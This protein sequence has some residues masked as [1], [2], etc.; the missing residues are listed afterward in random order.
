M[1]TAKTAGQAEKQTRLFFRL[2]CGFS[3]ARK[4]SWRRSSFRRR[5]FGFVFKPVRPLASL[6][7]SSPG[8]KRGIPFQSFSLPI[9]L[10]S[11]NHIA[12]R[13]NPN[14]LKT[15]YFLCHFCCF[16]LFWA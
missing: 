13:P 8:R 1:R 3:Y 14:F 10:L 6:Q 11:A 9:Q 4:L 15:I 16:A 7:L 2:A 5:L 12:P